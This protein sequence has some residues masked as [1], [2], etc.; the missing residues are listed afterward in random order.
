MITAA[1]ILF[2]KE[3]KNICRSGTLI[4]M[5]DFSFLD[6]NWDCDKTNVDKSRILPKLRISF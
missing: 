5:G 2:Y 3:L 4:L 6:F 1:P